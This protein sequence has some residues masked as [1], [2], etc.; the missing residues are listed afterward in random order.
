MDAHTERRM[1]AR[2]RL[3]QH[4][5]DDAFDPQARRFS[6]EKIR[7]I[8]PN[9]YYKIEWAKRVATLYM[10]AL[11]NGETDGRK[12]AG[13]VSPYPAAFVERAKTSFDRSASATAASRMRGA[14][15]GAATKRATARRKKRVRRVGVKRKPGP[16]AGRRRSSCRG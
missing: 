2:V 13:F 14:L 9:M 15:A 16:K 1:N 12:R 3:H 6:I 4:F 10:Q 7:I 11:R 5:D 8:H